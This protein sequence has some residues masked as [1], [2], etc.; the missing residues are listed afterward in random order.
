MLAIGAK[1]GK[2]MKKQQVKKIKYTNEPIGKIKIIP[3]FLPP[4][5]KLVLKKRLV[6][7]TLEL[8]EDSLN[9]FKR[10][11]EA[12]HTHYQRMIRALLDSY[13]EAQKK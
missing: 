11:A 9:F 10:E 3:N 13:A 6:K 4:P 2:Y 1:G 8:T 5:H 12:N 7:V